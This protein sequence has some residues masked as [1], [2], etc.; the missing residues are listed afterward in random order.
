MEF[1][2]VDFSNMKCCSSFK[3][4]KAWGCYCYAVKKFSVSITIL[5]NVGRM[6]ITGFAYPYTVMS[7]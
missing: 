2:E 4:A 1:C 3:M 5:V 6:C 7:N